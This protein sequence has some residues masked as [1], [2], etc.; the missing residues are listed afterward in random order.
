MKLKRN[1]FLMMKYNHI[2]IRRIR[3]VSKT[4]NLIQMKKILN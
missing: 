3:I 4:M 1:K 2:Q